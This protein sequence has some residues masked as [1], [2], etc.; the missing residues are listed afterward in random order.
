MLAA[1]SIDYRCV[2]AGR[3]EGWAAMSSIRRLKN[4]LCE[5]LRVHL[6]TGVRPTVPEAGRTLWDIYI[7]LA[8]TRT[9]HSSGPN[10]ISYVEIEAWRRANRWPLEPHHIGIIRA[11]DAVWLEHACAS[12]KMSRDGGKIIPR[13]SGQAVNPDAFD[14][15]FG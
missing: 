2:E 3:E 9:Y 4:Q 10:P 15:V 5:C 6:A 14:A 8:A 1:L 11:L 12:M 13:R 7:E